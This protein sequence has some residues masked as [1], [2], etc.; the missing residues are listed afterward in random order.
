MSPEPMP[1][2]AWSL[3]LPHNIKEPP[4]LSL[5]RPSTRQGEGICAGDTACGHAYPGDLKAL[6]GQCF[7][8]RF[9]PSVNFPALFPWKPDKHSMP[10]ML[11]GTTAC[12]KNDP[13]G[14]LHL[15]WEE[16]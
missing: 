10:T 2:G 16:L 3:H 5:R 14:K 13:V 15:G 1:F 11:L 9:E 4:P 6:R 7:C 12:G 8:V